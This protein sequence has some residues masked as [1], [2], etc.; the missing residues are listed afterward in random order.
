MGGGKF[1]MQKFPSNV[2]R[3]SLLKE[4]GHNFPLLKCVVHIK[5]PFP[6][7][8]VERRKTKGNFIVKKSGTLYP[9]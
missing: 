6:K 1:L 2:Y 5:C 9:R 4:M 3:Y 7:Y 8:H